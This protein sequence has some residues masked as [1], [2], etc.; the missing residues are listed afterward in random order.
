MVGG[1]TASNG[2]VISGNSGY[3]VWIMGAGNN[4]V[5]GNSIGLSSSGAALGNL[6][7]GVQL[8]SGASGN[9]VGGTSTSYRNLISANTANGVDVS[10]AGTTGNVV[11]G[12]DIGT[13]S[14]G[15]HALPNYN[16]VIIQNGATN[17]LILGS[18]DSPRSHFG[19]QL[20]WNP[21]RRHRDH[22]QHGGGSL[23]RRHRQR[24]HG[25]GQRESGV[26]I[27]AGA[28][29]N[30]IGGTSSGQGDVLSGNG[31]NGVYISDSG[32][33]GNLVEGDDI[34]TNSTG[35]LAVGNHDGVV[36]QNGAANNTIGGTSSTTRDLI[37]GNNWE[38]VHISGGGTSG[39][40]V[41]GDYIGVN[42][43]GSAAL[44]NVQS[45]VGIYAGASNNIIGGS[46]S[47]SGDVV[48]GNGSIR[49]VYHRRGDKRQ[50]H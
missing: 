4:D 11:E 47:G 18:A 43:G 34:G 1:P 49:R 27:Y 41:D 29:N 21:H 7:N 39:N 12:N 3:G 38:G 44:G 20:G 19:Q 25:A 13:D 46:V 23:H 9:F 35:S 6:G 45:G 40:V 10:G 31:S 2:N 32:T 36:I 26:A 8:D 22:R 24:V 50:R 5:W 14:T 28:S 37:S 42:A 48:S 16:G 30:T 17:N 33:I 15:S